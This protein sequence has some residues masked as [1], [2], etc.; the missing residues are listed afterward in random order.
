MVRLNSNRSG[1]RQDIALVPFQHL[2]LSSLLTIH[3]RDPSSPCLGQSKSQET[4]PWKMSN[5][6]ISYSSKTGDVHGVL[7]GCV[8]GS[9]HVDAAENEP[10]SKA[11]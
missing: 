3:Q 2:D 5:D 9:T 1:L 7:D 11:S 10:R 4:V 6:S 8:V